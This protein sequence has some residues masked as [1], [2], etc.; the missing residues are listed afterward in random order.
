MTPPGRPAYRS[1]DAAMDE[2]PPERRFR[3]YNRVH[4]VLREHG[5]D[6]AA[7]VALELAHEA[8]RQSPVIQAEIQTYLDALRAD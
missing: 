7:T 8:A 6:E 5:A 1:L 2:L 3:L 4:E